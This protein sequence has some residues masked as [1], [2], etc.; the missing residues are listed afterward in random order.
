VTTNPDTLGQGPDLTRATALSFPPAEYARRAG[1]VRAAVSAAGLDAVI[2]TTPENICYVT[3][4]HTP[5]YHIFQAAIVPARGEP[6]LVLRDIETDNARTL[7]WVRDIEQVRDLDG[8]ERVLADALRAR[9]L[10]EG[11]IGLPADSSFLSPARARAIAGALPEATVIDVRAIVETVRQTKSAA[12]VELIRRAAGV[13]DSAI[14]HAVEQL[15]DCETDSDVAAV[16]LNAITRGGSGYTG[17]PAYVVAGAASAAPHS[18][19]AGRPIDGRG[20]VW[21]ELS[22]SLDRYHG[23]AS[24]VIVRGGRDA[25]LDRVNAVSAAA[26][27]AMIA[28]MRPGATSGAVDAAGRDL[29]VAAGLGHAWRHR[30]GYSL[31]LSFPPGLGEGEI[32]DI[33][34]GDP[35][36]LQAGMV[37]HLIPILAIEGLGNVGCTETVLV[38]E[39]GGVSLCQLP[40]EVLYARP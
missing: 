9:G 3:G 28:A 39:D 24:R 11:R 32:I 16:V 37:F 23:A 18:V 27:E 38:T 30:A 33:K 29:V 19:H 6:F 34:P 1:A 22:A 35:R 10:G 40:R 15:D 25:D 5:G 26:L 21:V 31:G 20:N 13:V 36:P 17:S 2:L 14:V 12:E 8:P 7:S 4:F